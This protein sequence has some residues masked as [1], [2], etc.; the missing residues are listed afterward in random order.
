MS[1]SVKIKIEGLNSG[2]IVNALIEENVLIKNLKLKERSAVFTLGKDNEIKLQQI[3]KR[4]RKKYVVLSENN[5]IN[6]LKHFRYYFGFIVASILISVFMFVYNM[7]IYKVNVSVDK[8]LSYNLDEIT[9]L[10]NENKIISGMKKTDIDIS[11]IQNLIISSRND[12]AGC[13]VKQNGGSL[14]IVIYPGVLKENLST[15]NIY[16]KY[17]AVITDVE[18]FAGK[19]NLKLGDVVKVGDLLVENDNGADGKILGKIYYSDYI[20]YNE[21]QIVKELTGNFIERTDLMLFDKKLNKQPKN[22]EFTN[23]IEDICVFS[24]SK[25]LFIPVNLLKTKYQEFEYKEKVVKFETMENS[26][27]EELYLKLIEKVGDKNSITNVTY[28]VVTEN[29]LTRLDCFIECEID[30]LA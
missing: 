28:S 23:Y 13:A 21:N 4:Y 30:L 5:F 16:S 25:N 6:L 8:N 3:C 26:L 20:I 2:K 15:E 7:Y 14:D 12:V 17:N 18:I 9:E 11:K 22:I 29:N 19:S 24:V 1:G 27:K 10:L